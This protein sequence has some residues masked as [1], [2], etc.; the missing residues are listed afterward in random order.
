MIEKSSNLQ[1]IIPSTLA[2][3]KDLKATTDKTSTQASISKYNWIM[4]VFYNGYNIENVLLMPSVYFSSSTTQH[5][6]H[7]GSS[8]YYVNDNTVKF[9]KGNSDARIYGI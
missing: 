3:I 1:K 5:Y 8:V 2:V 6:D 9:T 4:V 7:D